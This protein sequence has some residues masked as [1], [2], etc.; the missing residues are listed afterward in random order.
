MEDEAV[1]G[2]FPY[3]RAE[4]K[5]PG[6]VYLHL[7]LVRAAFKVLPAEVTFSK[8]N[9]FEIN[10]SLHLVNKYNILVKFPLRRTYLLW[11]RTAIDE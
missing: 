5:C 2:Q 10:V 6:L 7:S 3:T 8:K 4:Q 11:L 9:I 1:V